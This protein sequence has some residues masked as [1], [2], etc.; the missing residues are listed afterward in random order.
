MSKKKQLGQFFTTNYEYILQGMNIPKDIENIMEPF[1]GNGDLLN[2]VNGSYNIKKYD[3][4]PKR[5]DV[6]YRNTLSDPPNYN[7]TFV[8]TNPPYLAR[9]KSEDKTIFDKYNEN[10]LYKCFLSLLLDY[11][12]IGG[13][14]IV[15][16]NFFSS[17]RKSDVKL[18][19]RFLKRF[20]ILRVN[21]FEE[22]VFND[23]SYSV[24][25]F[26]FMK[27]NIYVETIDCYIFPEN[28][29]IKIVLNAENNYTIAGHLYMLPNSGKYK[30]GRLVGT[31]PFNTNIVIK[32]ID[33]SIVSKLGLKIVKDCDI[34]RDLTPKSSERS[35]ATLTIEPN[36]S[37][38]QQQKLVEIFNE[39]MEYN[40]TLYN[41]MFLTNYRES[42]SIARKR[43]SFD[44]VYRIVGYI[45][46]TH[47]V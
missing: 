16:L 14:V 13:I 8:L 24:V 45:I 28:K 12:I 47:I 29:N 46:D 22:K 5:G 15:P 6:E 38:E 25:S 32:C 36:L 19:E 11:D 2:F 34:Y 1:C 35:Y 37:L 9:N 31:T 30:I 33:D 4:D 10:D 41:S 27:T 21:V 7:N 44:L 26:Q 43:I 3:I 40:R 23:T 39:F 17:I 18:R 20:N 42:N